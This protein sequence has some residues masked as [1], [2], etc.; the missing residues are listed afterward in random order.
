MAITVAGGPIASNTFNNMRHIEPKLVTWLEEKMTSMGAYHDALQRKDARTIY[1]LANM[2]C[3]GVRETTDNA[4]PLVELLQ[5]TIGD[6]GHEAWCMAQQ[7]SCVAFA[8][9]VTG[10]KSLLYASEGCLEVWEE[11]PHEMRVQ[12][13]P[14][15]GALTIWQH[16]TSWQGHCGCTGTYNPRTHIFESFEGNTT[17]GLDAK[18]QIIRDGGGSY[19]AMRAASGTGNMRVKGWLRPFPLLAD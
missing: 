12:S 4:G 18:G 8:E 9:Q 15:P 1:L 3:I 16:G 14:L 7:Q 13:I 19:R 6:S 17:G 11:S 10:V 2:A 5:K